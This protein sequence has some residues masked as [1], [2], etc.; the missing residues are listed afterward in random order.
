MPHDTDVT[1]WSPP[2]SHSRTRQEMLQTPMCLCIP[3]P[4]GVQLLYS[5]CSL[6]SARLWYSSTN[7]AWRAIIQ[8]PPLQIH[9]ESS[10]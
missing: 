2:A 1:F 5:T 9:K 10:M 6:H 3:L 7:S 8:P 4:P